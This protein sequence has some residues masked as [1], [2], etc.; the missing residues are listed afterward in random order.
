MD[1]GLME[2][3]FLLYIDGSKYGKKKYGRLMFDFLFHDISVNFI[4]E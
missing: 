3:I 4:K 1:C 2:N